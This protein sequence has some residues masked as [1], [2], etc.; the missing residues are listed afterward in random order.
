MVHVVG[1]DAVV[2]A[3]VLVLAVARAM[4]ETRVVLMAKARAEAATVN[5]TTPM[6]PSNSEQNWPTSRTSSSSKDRSCSN[7]QAEAE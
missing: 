6:P 2:L 7:P 5:G 3:V 1:V 4:P